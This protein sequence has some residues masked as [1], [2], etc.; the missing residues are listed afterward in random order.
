M[1]VMEKCSDIRESW[2][3]IKQDLMLSKSNDGIQSMIIAKYP[4]L[5]RN[6]VQSSSYNSHDTTQAYNISSYNSWDTTQ[7]TTTTTDFL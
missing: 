2:I 6:I 7:P 4:D 3:S 1:W 5:D